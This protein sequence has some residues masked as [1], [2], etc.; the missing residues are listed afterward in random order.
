[1]QELADQYEKEIDQVNKDA[2]AQINSCT[3]QLR[4][5]ETREN[6]RLQASLLVVAGPRVSR[7]LLLL[8]LVYTTMGSFLPDL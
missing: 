5:Q 2:A 4:Q 8:S 6:E 3:E 1:M 7:T